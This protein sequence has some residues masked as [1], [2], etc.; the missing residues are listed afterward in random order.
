MMEL[1]EQLLYEDEGAQSVAL[2][3]QGGRHHLGLVH[4]TL[5]DLCPWGGRP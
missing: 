4:K 5:V 1:Q 2:P 3:L